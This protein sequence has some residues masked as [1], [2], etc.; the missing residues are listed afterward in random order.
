MNG[1]KFIIVE[2]QIRNKRNSYIL[3]G[4]CILIILLL[5]VA[6]SYQIDSSKDGLI[7]G[8]VVT[9]ITIPLNLLTAKASIIMSVKGKEIDYDCTDERYLRVVRLVEGLSI[10]AGL[11][12]R[13]DIYILPT[14]I[15]NAFAGGLSHNSAYIGVT[16][17]L[18]D[19]MED[20][21]LEGVIAHEIAHVL[22]LDIMFSTVVAGLVSVMLIMAYMIDRIGRYGSSSKRK[23]DSN[24][25]GQLILA[26][27]LLAIVIKPFVR[28]IG[29][30]VQ[31]AVSRKREYLADATAVRL[32]GYNEGLSKALEKLSGRAHRYNRKEINEL[33]G[34]QMLAM[35]ISNPGEKLNSLFST[36]PPIEDRINKLRNMY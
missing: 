16:E 5:S 2:E 4:V 36:H 17:G 28:I 13:P 25:V 23:S 7:I 29:K 6:L 8:I 32:C 31:L 11:P 10:S 1:E 24:N 20:D 30:L 34:D 33:G 18:L 22:N 3:V 21:E 12:K 14:K 27:T 9:T 19:M 35:Y 26:I 15:P